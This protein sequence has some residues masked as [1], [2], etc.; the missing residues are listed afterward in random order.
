MKR[1]G[2]ICDREPKQSSVADILSCS[3]YICARFNGRPEFAR[4]ICSETFDLF[5]IEGGGEVTVSD[6][7][8]LVRSAPGDRAPIIVVCDT[9]SESQIARELDAGADDFLIQPSAT[10]L[11]AHIRAVL[12]RASHPPKVSGEWSVAEYSIDAVKRSVSLNG[13]IVQLSRREFDLAEFLFSNPGRKL[14]RSYINEAIWGR[15]S[16]ILGRSLDTHISRIRTKLRLEPAN[17][18]R[19]TALY[20]YGYQLELLDHGMDA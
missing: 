7:R 11:L 2:V 3:G 9:A 20:G 15:D 18:V 16:S 13:Q 12:R 14:S 10:V 8:D 6:L 19:L 17:G 1:I 4:T 5:V